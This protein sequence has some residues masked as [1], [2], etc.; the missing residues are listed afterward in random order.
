MVCDANTYKMCEGRIK[1]TR[2][3]GPVT[4]LN[5]FIPAKHLPIPIALPQLEPCAR[6]YRPSTVPGVVTGIE[7]CICFQ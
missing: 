7:N 5:V 4:T 6:I 2:T 1:N 3:P